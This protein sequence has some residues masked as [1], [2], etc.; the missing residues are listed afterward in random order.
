MKLF[1]LIAATTLLLTTACQAQI[2][3]AETATV[4]V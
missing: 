1:S 3:N 2:K 4:K